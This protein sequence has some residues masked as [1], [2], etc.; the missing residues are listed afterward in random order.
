MD[1]AATPPLATDSPPDAA[2]PVASDRTNIVT[3]LLGLWFTVGLL[4]DAWAHNNVPRLETFFTPWHAVFYS[5]FAATAAWIAWTVRD[6]LRSGRFDV[7]AV[8]VGYAS[9]AVAVAVVGYALA[10]GADLAWHT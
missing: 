4:L 10:G 1:T 3:M 8:P 5:G 9:S 6:G 7:R 2:R